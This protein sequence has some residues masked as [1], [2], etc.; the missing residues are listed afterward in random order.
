MNEHVEL[1]KK[2]RRMDRIVVERLRANPA[3][4]EIPRQNLER[5]MKKEKE[6]FGYTDRWWRFWKEIIDKAP[7]EDVLLILESDDPSFE[8]LQHCSPFAG[9]LTHEE[10]MAICKDKDDQ[11]VAA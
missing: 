5:W 6:E 10:V 1:V 11:A 9:I 3:L 7:F 8:Q 4:M 2:H